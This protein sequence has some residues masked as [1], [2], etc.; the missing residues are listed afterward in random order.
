MKAMK[1]KL[2]VKYFIAAIF[3]LSLFSFAYVNLHA[4][5]KHPAAYEQKTDSQH[6][7]M[8]EEDENEKQKL[9][10]P[11]VAILGRIIDLVQKLALQDR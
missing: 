2:H 4:A 11:D 10:V 7:V 9:A 8:V 6:P 3:V 1:N 5:F